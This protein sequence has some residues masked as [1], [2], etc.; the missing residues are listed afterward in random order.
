M[1]GPVRTR[2]VISVVVALLLA[3]CGGGGTQS[4]ASPS[5]TVQTTTP[6]PE[7]EC[8]AQTTILMN[9]RS[10][11]PLC[12]EVA[13]GDTLTIQSNSEARH[14]FTLDKPKVDFDVLEGELAE[15]EVVDLKKKQY[16][17]YCKYHTAMFVDVVVT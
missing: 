9:N 2:S 10:F 3:G 4:Q 6:P 14:S 17:F 8:P 11:D 7:E 5:P 1:G 15:F 13:K 16:R 12:V